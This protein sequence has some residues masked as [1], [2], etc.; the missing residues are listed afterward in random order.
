VGSVRCLAYSSR[1]QKAWS[2]GPTYL[3]QLLGIPP[4][5]TNSSKNRQRTRATPIPALEVAPTPEAIEDQ[6]FAY[7]T[8]LPQRLHWPVVAKMPKRKA[9]QQKYYAVRAG[10]SPGVYRTWEECLA[11]I[12]GY[13]GAIC[14]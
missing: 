9:G 6:A 13:P 4:A 1:V 11:Q 5:D 14:A 7:P 2:P 12:N 10:V 8:H 3:D